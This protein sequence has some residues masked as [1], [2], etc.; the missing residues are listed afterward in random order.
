MAPVVFLDFA[1][2][3]DTRAPAGWHAA[4]ALA[5]ADKRP[6]PAQPV[7]ASSLLSTIP[8]AADAR[9]IEVHPEVSF[10]ALM[11]EPIQWSK[12]SWN[13]LRIRQRA[14]AQAEISIPKELGDVGGIPP[15]DIFD[16][17]VAAWSARRY[18]E[19]SAAS[20]PEGSRNGVRE[21]I[22]Y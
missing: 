9:V 22:W 18:A 5:Q 15:A 7:A 20:L 21:V 17:A 4:L 1:R 2:H 12:A 16:A 10:R 8:P 11:G 6:R 3:D 14:L 13:G 19:G